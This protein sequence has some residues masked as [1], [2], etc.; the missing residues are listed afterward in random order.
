VAEKTRLS[1]KTDSVDQNEIHAC[2]II[3]S[4]RNSS[5]RECVT[6]FLPSNENLAEREKSAMI[7]IHPP[8][9]NLDDDCKT[10]EL[11]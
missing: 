7:L 8:S 4:S 5:V 9:S 2:P 1:I 10:E 11:E 3:Y 6:G